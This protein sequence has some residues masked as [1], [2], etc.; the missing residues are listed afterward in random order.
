MIFPWFLGKYVLKMM[1]S[2]IFRKNDI[3]MVVMI[4]DMVMSYG[5]CWW[6]WWVHGKC[7]G[8]FLVGK[9]YEATILVPHYHN[10]T[11]FLREWSC[12]YGDSRWSCCLSIVIARISELYFDDLCGFVVI[13]TFMMVVAIVNYELVYGGYEGFLK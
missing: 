1:I 4:F 7:V 11:L 8:W 5:K 9:S 13:V 12:L 2:M 6:L 10:P 3:K